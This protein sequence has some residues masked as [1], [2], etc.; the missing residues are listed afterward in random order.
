MFVTVI[1][2]GCNRMLETRSESS[3]DEETVFSEYSLARY[4]VNGI[5]ETYVFTSAYLNDYQQIY[6]VNTDVDIWSS[7]SNGYKRDIASYKT[8]PTAQ[9]VDA[10]KSTD[11]YPGLFIG[12]ERANYCIRN[13]RKYAD[14]EH[15]AGMAS[16]LGE[17][18][19]QRA[20]YYI[21]LMN[22]Y[23]EV[24]ARFEPAT[25]DTQ[26]LPKADKDV[27]Y[28]QIL[29][30][31]EEAAGLMKYEDQT[32]LTQ[33]GKACA[34]GMYARIALQAAGYSLRPDEG[35]VNTGDPGRIRKSTD[36][37][38]Q[39]EVL[40]PKAITALEELIGSGMY[41]LVDNYEELWKSFCQLETTPFK[42]VIYG[43]P[44]GQRGMFITHSG[45]PNKKYNC[46]TP[47]RV[48]LVTTLY[49][50][51]REGD[52]RR[53]VTCCPC[54]YDTTG[55][56]G[57]FKSDIMYC[58]KFRFDWL[59]KVHTLSTKSDDDWAKQTYL[60]YADILLMASELENGMKH[61]D[62]A[63]EYMRPVLMRAYNGWP[64]QVVEVE[65]YLSS[66][67]DSTEFQQAIMDQR[68]L[69]FA[70]ERL[71]RADLIRWGCLQSALDAAKAD[72]E[73][74]DN[75]RGAYAGYANKLFWRYAERTGDPDYGTLYS[76]NVELRFIGP[77]D[78][79]PSGWNK[80]DKW[81]SKMNASMYN[82]IYDVEYAPDSHMYRPIPATVITA[83]MGILKNDYGY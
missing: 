26:Y 65:S 36:P 45:L 67:S 12:I 35:K 51:Y 73:D 19:T 13:L 60:R 78:T 3:Y 11:F 79:E 81:F 55:L 9:M 7:T 18:L 10:G 69:E 17:A 16:L 2:A 70:G 15:N 68:A 37:E 14:V 71:R 22:V 34:Q 66:L 59:A 74:F 63:K 31:L 49:F 46:D 83:N 57:T 4:A 39:P 5:Y 38:L 44:F 28:K 80:V 29:G 77:D 61:L 48:A 25:Q 42:E 76:K 58:G 56:A 1:L 40:Y 41:R 52:Q 53:D 30:D 50:K 62:K 75:N 32:R 72:M 23:G 33:P 64:N 47:N 20:I 27:L 43:L 54:Q 21:D 24:P 8:L 82:G 6:G